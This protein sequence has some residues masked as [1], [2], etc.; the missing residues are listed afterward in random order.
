MFEKRF[1]TN[2]DLPCISE[3]TDIQLNYSVIK[4]QNK[5]NQYKTAE[6]I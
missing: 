2:S 4:M 3:C 1:E 6:K 5:N